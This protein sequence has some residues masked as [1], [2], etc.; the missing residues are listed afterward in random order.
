MQYGQEIS[1][2][3]ARCNPRPRG[4]SLTSPELTS[5]SCQVG[6][7]VRVAALARCWLARSA[8]VIPTRRTPQMQPASCVA[9]VF[10]PSHIAFAAM[11]ALAL[12]SRARDL[13]WPDRSIPDRAYRNGN[14]DRDSPRFFPRRS[15]A[16]CISGG[17]KQRSV[18]AIRRSHRGKPQ[19][20]ECRAG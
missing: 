14:H 5:A 17:Y 4:S 11:R 8:T 12:I 9:V 18:R 20:C 7:A 19:S 13:I 2:P 10:L 3:T 16:R 1:S 15:N 6:I